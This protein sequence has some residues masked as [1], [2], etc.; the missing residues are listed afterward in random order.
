MRKITYIICSL[1]LFTS[2]EDVVQIDVP[3]EEPRLV[4][5]ASLSF[6]NPGD[7]SMDE[8]NIKLSLTAPFFD[9]SIPAVGNATVFI[10]NL[11][12]NTVTLFPE[13][14]IMGVYRPENGLF[15]PRFNIDY[16][17]TVIYAGETYNATTRYIP[18]VP[19]DAVEQG[20]GVLF[21]GDETEVIISFTDDG[22][23][24]DFYLFDFDFDLY[25]ANEDKFYQG[26]Q[27]NFSYFYE[28]MVVGQQITIKILGIDQRFFTYM[29]LLIEQ[30]GQNSGGPFEAPPAS[31]RGNIVNTA[32]PDNFALGYFNLSEGYS[33]LF[34]PE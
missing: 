3:T 1:I 14:G 20:D 23:R 25:L 34:T 2:C 16:E 4:I 13:S 12:D 17:L 15:R 22:N 7:P 6:F 11:E 21:D 24:D 31:V 10:T 29:E 8:S 28:E 27:F 9:S 32:N 26:Q 5:D 33:I 19:I 18:S 30:S